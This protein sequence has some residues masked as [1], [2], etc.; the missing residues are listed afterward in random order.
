MTSQALAL[1]PSTFASRTLDVP[2]S[3]VREGADVVG[4]DANTKSLERRRS[5]ASKPAKP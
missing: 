1:L 5:L 3:L 4:R 2:Q